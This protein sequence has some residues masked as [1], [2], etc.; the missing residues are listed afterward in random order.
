MVSRDCLF[1]KKE[2]KIAETPYQKEHFLSPMAGEKGNTT[3]YADRMKRIGGNVGVGVIEG[4]IAISDC[5][6]LIIIAYCNGS[7]TP[8]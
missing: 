7:V 2:A 5:I 1:G 3:P 8:I 6:Y 4:Y